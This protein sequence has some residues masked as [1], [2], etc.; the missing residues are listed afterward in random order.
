[1]VFRSRSSPREI[2]YSNRPI[3]VATEYIE[4]V[5]DNGVRYLAVSGKKDINALVQAA[6]EGTLVYN[7]LN[8]YSLG[9][10]GVLEKVKG[11]FGDVTRVP[12]SLADTVNMLNDV[13][14]RFADLPVDIKQIFNNSAMEFSNSCLNGDVE[15]RLNSFVK[16]KMK[17]KAAKSEKKEDVENG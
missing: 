7:I 5:D 17:A 15:L 11:F 1:M 2:F 12:T 9:D 14:K 6:L 8:R 13:N 10:E 16:S 4:K 3:G